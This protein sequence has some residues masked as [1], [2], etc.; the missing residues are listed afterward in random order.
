MNEEI[1]KYTE[2]FHNTYEM[3]APKYGYETRGDTKQFDFDSPNGKLM[4]ATI[5]KIVYPILE[6][7][8]QLK[9]QLQ[10]KEDIINKA[11]EYIKD[12]ANIYTN[13]MGKEVGFFKR[14]NDGWTPI[15]LLEIL[16]NKGE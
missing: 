4:Y 13:I 9:E 5:E 16:D 8:Q 14:H 6:E 12:N 7:N 15:E 3:L 1:K 10:Q 2:M 11:K